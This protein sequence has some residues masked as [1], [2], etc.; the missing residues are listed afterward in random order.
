MAYCESWYPKAM[1]R[2][3]RRDPT[4]KR[5]ELL[6]EYPDATLN[7]LIDC[8][9]VNPNV[10]TELCISSPVT[11]EMVIKLARYIAISNTIERLNLE[12]SQCNQITY[13]AIAAALHVNTSLRVFKLCNDQTV[14][15]NQIEAIFIDA[16]IVNRNRPINSYWYLYRSFRE[17]SLGLIMSSFRNSYDQLKEK[18]DQLGHPNMRSL[19]VTYLVGI[20]LI[21]HSLIGHSFIDHTL[22]K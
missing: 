16:L 9:L 6:T 7:N 10:I 11:N 1:L 5:I 15:V 19:L 18:A 2:L 4:L 21:D 20:D 13:D 8:L 14:D 22:K 17:I 12:E 3:K